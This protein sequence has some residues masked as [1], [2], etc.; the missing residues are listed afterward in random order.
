M[1]QE[2][3]PFLTYF[4][5]VVAALGYF[6]DIYDLI[7]FNVVKKESLEAIML[8]AGAEEL[9]STGM[10]LF[11]MQMIGMLLG[12]I[13]WGIWGDKKGRLSV[14]FGSILLYSAANIINA[15][16]T[17]I[18]LY[19]VVRVIAGI[20]LAG[21][22]GAGITLVSETLSKEK[23]GYGTMIIVSFGALGA[24]AAALVGANGQAIGQ[25]LESIF[26]IAFA[27]WQV[28]YI[29]GGLLG[30]LLLLLRVGTIESGMFKNIQHSEVS[31]GDIRM[32]FNNKERFFKYLN[33]ILIGLPIWYFIGLIVANSEIIW[34]KDLN[35]QGKVVNGTALMYAYI[36]LSVGDVFSGLISQLLRSRRK[37]VFIYLA[38]SVTLMICYLFFSFG[39]SLRGFYLLSF[40][41]GCATGYWA[42][43]VTIAAEQFGTNIRSTVTNTV[44]NFV[45][46]SVPL[47]TM[48]FQFVTAQSFNNATSAFIVGVLCM[49]LSFW[50]IYRSKET[51]AKDL[52]YT[53][54]YP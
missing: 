51:F 3:K 36:G 54:Q 1:K 53:E 7:L 16:V 49:C 45:R 42:I 47:I 6:V 20:G 23:R 9:K 22:L 37:V 48:L 18:P 5:I 32:L 44:P 14:L 33:C 31:K 2:K 8:G 40:L 41:I 27:N 15:F 34:A 13:L 4:I 25:L 46:G 38:M 12:G 43:F 35:V 11:N 24:V 17:T 26:H 10:F 52:N 50:A 29:L 30:L 21:E 19:A 28:A 39:I